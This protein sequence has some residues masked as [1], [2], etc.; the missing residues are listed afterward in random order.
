MTI[1]EVITEA[2]VALYGSPMVSKLLLLKGG[3][4]MRLFDGLDSRLS[5]DADFSV[6]D[7]IDPDGGL[8]KEMERCMSEAFC[9]H[10]YEVM[11][12]RPNKRPKH[13]R[14][15]FP[16]SWGG[17]TCEFKLT[18]LRHKDKSMETK[19]RNA[20]VPD[21]ANSPS[22]ALDLSEHE[23]CGKQRT[24]NLHGVRVRA[25]SREMLVVEKLRAICQQHPDYPFR[26]ESRNRARDFFDIH[27]L[28][29]DTDDEFLRRCRRYVSPVF[30]AKQVP[31]WILR[32]LWDDGW[33]DA[34]RRGFDQVK[35]TVRG[36]LHDFDVYL[37]H[38]RFLIQEICPE[39]PKREP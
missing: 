18:D 27:E 25:Y 23:Y 28:T 2:I 35:D 17:W 10:G 14:S 38:V 6:E 33:V 26:Q 5:I 22:I 8:F 13:R 3:S 1:E 39:I 20:L 16:E 24:R 9:V 21:G 4:A 29:T 31:L 36:H 15:G 19:R 34:H 32:E 11:D 37:E 12:F 7:A 30:E